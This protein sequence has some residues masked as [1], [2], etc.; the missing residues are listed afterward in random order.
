ME[1]ANERTDLYN[2]E[3]KARAVEK[4]GRKRP[5][6]EEE[7]AGVEAIKGILRKRLETI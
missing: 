5:G 2:Q 6:P 1:K 3:A 4:E 7:K